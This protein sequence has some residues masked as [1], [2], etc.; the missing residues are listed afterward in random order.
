[1]TLDDGKLLVKLARSGMVEF[2]KS[3]TPADKQTIGP[4]MKHLTTRFHPASVTLRSSGKLLAR[5]FRADTNVCR[6]VLA[7]ALDAMR[8]SNLPDRVT[9]AVLAA[10]TVEV[11]IHGRPRAVSP[12]ELGDC[13]VQG[14]TGV[15]ISRGTVRGSVLPSTTYSLGLTADQTRM[16]CLAKLPKTRKKSARTD[17]WSIFSSKH[18]VGYPDATV[19]QLFRGKILI[20][21]QGLT[22]EIFS[23]SA[24]AAGLF[25]INGQ[26]SD[27]AYASPNRKAAIHEHL[28]ATY[29]MAKLSRRNKSKLF[30]ASVNRALAYAARFVLADDKQA[31]VLAKS[32]K[33][34]TTE[35]PTRA[36]AW[37]LLAISELPPDPANKKLAEKLARALQQ[38][39]VSVVGPDHGL[40][41]PGQLLDWSA[42]L[43]ALRRSLPKNERTTKL[44]APLRETMQ[45]WSKSGQKLSPLVFRGTGGMTA[46]PKWRQID[47]SDL[48]DRR[49]GFV[50]SRTE[51]TTFDT[52][53]AAVC[54]AESV[55]SGAVAREDKASISKQV[56][57]A[58]QFC[59]QMLYR[60]PE[61]WWA[62]KPA[63]MIGGIRVS[64][65]S[66]SVNLE[67]CAAA[68]EAFLLE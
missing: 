10:M 15:T 58:R 55:E 43:L 17:A 20:P 46:L 57:R 4:E 18:Y 5:S 6:S 22:A 25:L 19:V 3:R 65:S 61:A 47:D 41:T 56:L 49:G 50:S 7:A 35:N 33:G 29:A 2:I 34:R 44:L 68:I 23:D 40:A 63:K 31:R 28:Y 66:A 60:S 37:L 9:P 32:A 36:T 8:S 16:T 39:V 14:L 24:A 12:N 13:M 67:A 21:P 62:G 51:P 38:D 30:S 11:E 1:M 26:G 45:A 59:C 48:P 27:G 53:M 42:A 64:P 52:A 54:L